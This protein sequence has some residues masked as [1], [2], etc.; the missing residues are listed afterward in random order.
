MEFKVFVKASEDFWNNYLKD[1]YH[2]SFDNQLTKNRKILY[3]SILLCTN[4]NNHFS[5]ELLGVQEG[6]QC[7]VVKA[8]AEISMEKYLSQFDIEETEPL[9]IFE[10]GIT[11]FPSKERLSL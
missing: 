3:P 10:R 8:H 4:A 5:V 9:Y 7:L 2:N 1:I 6:F 11:P